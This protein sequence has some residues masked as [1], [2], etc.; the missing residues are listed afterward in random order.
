M[1]TDAPRVAAFS[2]DG[3]WLVAMAWADGHVR[4][5]RW[6]LD[7]GKLDLDCALPSINPGQH[8]V[9][10]GD[11][12]LLLHAEQPRDAAVL[13]DLQ[14]RMPVRYYSLEQGTH[15]VGSLDGRHWFAHS[16]R[17][18]GLQLPGPPEL[19]AVQSL[20]PEQFA[21]LG[22][23]AKVALTV[24]ASVPGLTG[25][26]TLLEQKLQANRISIDPAAPCRVVL[27]VSEVTEAVDTGQPK[28]KLQE[29]QGKVQLTV[30]D[31]AGQPA[32]DRTQRIPLVMT[33][34]RPGLP[35]Q[36]ELRSE[37][38]ADPQAAFSA[39]LDKLAL[40]AALF[41]SRWQESIGATKLG[42]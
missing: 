18:Q 39:V 16:A 2:P 14:N 26:Q 23:G 40:P 17:L 28:L 11:R 8:L 15:A 31:A 10:L 38:N 1:P 22:P 19:A 20:R 9:W 6:Q 4:A 24:N 12:Y 3:R 34:N 27:N 21:V 25:L 32:W 36:A 35:A 42:N 13:I 7:A 29:R 5:C 41:A 30:L 37:A 33:F